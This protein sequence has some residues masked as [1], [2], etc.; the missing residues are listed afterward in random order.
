MQAKQ[1]ESRVDTIT[2]A[3]EPNIDYSKI[4]CPCLGELKRFFA[5]C[6]HTYDIEPNPSQSFFDFVC[7]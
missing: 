7:Y 1:F 3:G 6:R 2:I 4:R 5:G